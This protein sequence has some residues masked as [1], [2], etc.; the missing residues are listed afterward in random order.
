[1][2]FNLVEINYIPIFSLSCM[3]QKLFFFSATGGEGNLAYPVCFQNRNWAQQTTAAIEAT[4]LLN[5]QLHC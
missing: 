3:Y 2:F 5:Q 1:M 4:I